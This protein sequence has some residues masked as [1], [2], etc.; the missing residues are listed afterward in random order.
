MGKKLLLIIMILIVSGCN[1]K[2]SFD[3]IE[4][5][6]IDLVEYSNEYFEMKI[7]K[8]WVV[9][10]SHSDDNYLLRVYDPTNPVNQIFS[11]LDS[12]IILKEKDAKTY[13]DYLASITQSKNDIELSKAIVIKD[14]S[15]EDFYNNY[16]VIT[17]YIKGDHLAFNFP[18]FKDF[19]IV[20]KK[21]NTLRMTFTE[22][23][24]SGEGLFYVS[25]VDPEPNIFIGIDI[26]HYNYSNI[27]GITT[28]KDEFINNYD[29]LME[30]LNSLKYK[31]DGNDIQKIS[32]AFSDIW[33]NRQLSYDILSQ[34][35]YDELNN[36]ERVYNVKTNNIYKAYKGFIKEMKPEDYKKATNDMYLKS[37][38]GYIE[39]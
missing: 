6:K 39:K 23:N 7:P 35:N 21:D 29:V 13:Y 34:K 36:Y 30:S 26:A 3:V 20:E 2:A 28:V 37:I 24:V 8:G 17:N 10:T 22:G 38:N 18:N 31:K 11:I 27:V 12:G 14:V 4:K 15:V 32:K 1:N 33:T 9:S 19:N 16:D 5:E 25:Y